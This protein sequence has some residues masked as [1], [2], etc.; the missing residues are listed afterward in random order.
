M[1][2]EQKVID[3]LK[4]KLHKKYDI[5]LEIDNHYDLSQVLDSI[6]LVE[7]AYIVEEKYNV[8]FLDNEIDSFKSINGILCW[9]RRYVDMSKSS[10]STKIDILT[11]F[12]IA[13]SYKTISKKT[14]TVF[15]RA[16]LPGLN[17]KEMRA[18]LSIDPFKTEPENLPHCLRDKYDI[19]N[20]IH[21]LG[22]IYSRVS[23][24]LHSGAYDLLEIPLPI[25]D[26]NIYNWKVGFWEL[27]GL[28]SAAARIVTR[29]INWDELINNEIDKITSLL[30]GIAHLPDDQLHRALAVAQYVDA[31]KHQYNKED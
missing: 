29:Y 15:W 9:L 14:R 17:D 23:M 19:V 22:Y 24:R 20:R 16:E 6:E 25:D 7:F 4:K 31:H 1:L 30:K 13:A 5:P 28:D 26:P 2:Q 18:L 10:S 11:R 8:A 12:N 27:H 3:W 21:H